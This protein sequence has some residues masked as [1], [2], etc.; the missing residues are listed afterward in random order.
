M[1]NM[2]GYPDKSL[3]AFHLTLAFSTLVL[4]TN[5]YLHELFSS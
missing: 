4:M 2:Y 5:C 3:N 1:K